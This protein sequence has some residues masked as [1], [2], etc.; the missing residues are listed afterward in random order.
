[1]N[2]MIKVAAKDIIHSKC[3]RVAELVKELKNQLVYE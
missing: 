2:Y 1:M 3:E